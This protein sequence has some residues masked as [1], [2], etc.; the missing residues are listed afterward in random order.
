MAELIVNCCK[1][2][3]Q[4]TDG[5]CVGSLAKFTIQKKKEKKKCEHSK[6]FDSKFKSISK[7]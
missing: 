2:G 7:G 5:N 1:G 4:Q 6:A 3:F